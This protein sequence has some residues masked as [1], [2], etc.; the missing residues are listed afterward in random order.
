M[1]QLNVKPMITK[2]NSN[3]NHT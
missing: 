1:G 3:Y 2:D